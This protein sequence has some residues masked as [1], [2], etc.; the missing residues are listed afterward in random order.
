MI[1]MQLG[2]LSPKPVPTGPREYQNSQLPTSKAEVIALIHT[3]EGFH[4]RVTVRDLGSTILVECGRPEDA[5]S[6]RKLAP[7]WVLVSQRPKWEQRASFPV[8]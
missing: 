6:V 2:M 3:W 7:G 4:G 1:T 8:S 5:K